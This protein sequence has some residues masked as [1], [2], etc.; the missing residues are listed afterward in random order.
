[1]SDETL[2]APIRKL[3]KSDRDI[4]QDSSEFPNTYLFFRFTIAFLA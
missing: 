3:F 4:D 2:S 1:M